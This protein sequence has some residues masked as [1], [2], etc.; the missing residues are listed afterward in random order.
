MLTAWLFQHYEKRFLPT[1]NDLA[2][3]VNPARGKSR[4]N[5]LR[6]ADR[7]ISIPARLA[8]LGIQ[9]F[10]EVPM[11]FGAEKMSR[12]GLDVGGLNIA[13]QFFTHIAYTSITNGVQE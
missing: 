12:Q 6:V 8:G 11:T 3:P 9:G 13:V 1:M 5:V 7:G 4:E 10:Q 2:Q